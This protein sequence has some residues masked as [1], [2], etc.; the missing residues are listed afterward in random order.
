M[1]EPLNAPVQNYSR[2]SHEELQALLEQG[3]RAQ[4]RAAADH[5]SSLFGILG[6]LFAENRK[7]YTGYVDA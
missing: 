2:L 6:L 3:R 1:T 7:P 4:A 5:F